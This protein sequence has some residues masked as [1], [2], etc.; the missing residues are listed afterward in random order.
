L[1]LVKNSGRSGPFGSGPEAA[2]SVN[3]ERIACGLSWL[4]Q[5][6]APNSTRSRHS[7]G[8][9]VVA[10]GIGFWAFTRWDVTKPQGDEESGEKST[11][12]QLAAVENKAITEAVS[13]FGTVV[14]Q[15]GK[16]V[17]INVPFGTVV[18]HVMVTRGQ[19]LQ[20]GDLLIQIS[21]SPA[22]QL[23]AAKPG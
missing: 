10:I 5:K 19:S 4:K 20:L 13:T 8:G 23:P 14:P 18:R 12:V 1:I 21:A 17:S 11:Q 6:D 3:A 16:I 9:L 22:A 7:S 15:A 2:G